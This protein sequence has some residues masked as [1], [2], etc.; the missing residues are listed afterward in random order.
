MHT[1]VILNFSASWN[2]AGLS[3]TSTETTSTYDMVDAQIP[4]PRCGLLRS[5]FDQTRFLHHM[6]SFTQQTCHPGIRSLG[7]LVCCLSIATILMPHSVRTFCTIPMQPQV[8]I[9]REVNLARSLLLEDKAWSPRRTNLDSNDRH[10]AGNSKHPSNDAKSLFQQAW[11]L[12]TEHKNFSGS[13]SLYEEALKL[14]P[15]IA[16]QTSMTMWSEAWGLEN[17]RGYPGELTSISFC[18]RPSP[19]R[20]R[21]SSM[22]P[23]FPTGSPAAYR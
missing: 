12:Q 4:A 11:I 10:S 8:G 1:N 2:F 22:Q 14:N 7:K 18:S 23:A 13:A 21:Q 3:I 5:F 15:Q 17:I 19:E 16:R 20:R 6:R 9:F